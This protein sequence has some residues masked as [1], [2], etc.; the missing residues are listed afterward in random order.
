MVAWALIR[1]DRTMLLLAVTGVAS[2]TLFTFLVFFLGGYFSPDGDSGDH[3][4]LLALITLYPST[5]ITVFF[6]VALACAASAT[7]DGERLTV[8]EAIRM[9]YGKRWR[10]ALWSLIASIVGTLI[11]ELANRLPGGARLFGWLLGSV[12][13]LA[14]IFVVPILAIE[15]VGTVDALKRSSGMVKRRWGEGLTGSIS[16]GAW[17]VVAA[18]PLAILLGI[19]AAFL[20]QQPSTGVVLIGLSVLGLIA[21]S[22]AAAATRQVFAV[23][24]YRYAIDAPIGGFATSDLEYPFAPAREKR[25]SWILRIG[26]PIL[27]LLVLLIVIGIIVGPSERT[28]AQGYFHVDYTPQQAAGLTAGSPVVLNRSQ[29]GSVVSTEIDGAAV[30]VVFRVDPRLKDLIEA[31]PAYVDH[32]QGRAYIR[33]GG[34]P[35]RPPTAAT[36]AL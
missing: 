29:I 11:A 33:I 17:T 2:A 6:N 8:G 30:L 16:I 5:L 23:A 32:L 10:I 12:W 3:L 9:A 31:T 21:I 28:A 14:T 24:L 27:G 25:K 19:G 18:V 35:P 4:G 34:P 20:E 22:V 7:F 1:S 26:G 15:G 13:G 36:S